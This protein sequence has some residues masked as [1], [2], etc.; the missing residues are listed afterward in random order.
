MIALLNSARLNAGKPSLGFVNPLL[1]A[2]ATNNTMIFNDILPPF[3]QSTFV[4]FFIHLF[5]LFYFI[6]FCFVL[7][8]FILFVLFDSIIH[9][10]TGNNK[11]TENCCGTVGFEATAGWDP[12]ILSFYFSIF[13]F[14]YF[15][16]FLFCYFLF[17]ILYFLL[18][19]AIF[20]YLFLFIFFFLFLFL[21]FFRF[22][23]FDFY[24]Y[25]C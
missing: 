9:F 16:I 5:I 18:Y 4:F 20:I 17:S 25:I 7:F 10:T 19:F 23:I 21:Y 24:F 2:A 12:G 14:F 11:C 22:Q 1:Y 13:L 15:S 8:C 3:P 6:L